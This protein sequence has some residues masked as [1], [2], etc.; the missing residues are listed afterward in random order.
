MLQ[1]VFTS[2]VHQEPSPSEIIALL[3]QRLIDGDISF[4]QYLKEREKVE[5]ET[6]EKASEDPLEF[7]NISYLE[8]QNSER[9]LQDV[10]FHIRRNQQQAQ[11]PT[12]SHA[13]IVDIDLNLV[14]LR[15]IRETISEEHEQASI[16]FDPP[17]ILD[18]QLAN[19]NPYKAVEVEG[20]IALAAQQVKDLLPIFVPEQRGVEFLTTENF[21]IIEAVQNVRS[22]IAGELTTVSFRDFMIYSDKLAEVLQA[23]DYIMQTSQPMYSDPTNQEQQMYGAFDTAQSLYGEPIPLYREPSTSWYGFAA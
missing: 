7:T 12:I 19:Q 22:F 11:V 10:D 20:Q 1:E 6:G 23:I 3:E 14:Q 5:A 18:T 15:T 17:T 2:L 13:Q 21:K 8:L 9:G 16:L 4:E